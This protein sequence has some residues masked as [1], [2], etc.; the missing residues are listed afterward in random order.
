MLVLCEPT[1][2]C[3][4]KDIKI[5]LKSGW[6]TIVTV[7]ALLWAITLKILADWDVTVVGNRE[8]YIYTWLQAGKQSYY[9]QLPTYICKKKKVAP[10]SDFI[11][12]FWILQWPKPWL[13]IGVKFLSTILIVGLLRKSATK[14]KVCRPPISCTF[15]NPHWTPL[16]CK[17]REKRDVSSDYKITFTP[18]EECTFAIFIYNFF[19]PIGICESPD[20][21][22]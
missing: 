19:F 14:T 16:L 7:S 2:Y 11:T 1:Q 22:N 5:S 18:S 4:Y 12:F 15:V 13:H 20:G 10:F 21:H 8:L 6:G 9:Y 17:S 3:V